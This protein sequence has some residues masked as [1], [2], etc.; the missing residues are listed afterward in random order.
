MM[1][2]NYIGSN[3]Q[4]ITFN[5]SIYFKYCIRLFDEYGNIIILQKK[6]KIK[7]YKQKN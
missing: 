4:C 7:E 3:R 6:K 5:I 1:G 2:N